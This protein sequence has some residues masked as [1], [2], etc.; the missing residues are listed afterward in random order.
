MAVVEGMEVVKA[1]EA[2]DGTPPKKKVMIADSGE[3]EMA[4][5]AE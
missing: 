4:E 2:L 1:I 3:L 5:E